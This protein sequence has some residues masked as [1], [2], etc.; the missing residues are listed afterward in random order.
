MEINSILRN[1]KYKILIIITLLVVSCFLTYYF[2]FIIKTGVVFTHFFYIPIILAT[3]WWRYKGLIV[4]AFLSIMLIFS[5]FISGGMNV[6]L[7]EDYVRALMFIVVGSVVAYLSERISKAEKTLS[8]S[9]EKYRSV[10]ESA[11]EAIITANSNGYI[12]S[13]NNGAQKIF[14]YEKDEIL[15]KSVEILIPEEYKNVFREGLAKNGPMTNHE[16]NYEN[17]ELKALRKDGIK[18]PFEIS[19]AEWESG[20]EKFFT[21]ILRDITERKKT[22]ELKNRLAS[23]V[24]YSD[25]AI[26]SKDLNGVINSWNWSAENIYGY[27]A[28]EIIGKPV[29]VLVPENHSNEWVKILDDIKKG[30]KIDHYETIRLKKSGEIINVS[31]TVSPIMDMERIIGAST[32]ARDI[33]ERK[34]AEK[35]LKESEEKFREL[36]NSAN[37]MISLNLMDENGLPGKFIEVNDEGC[38]RLGYTRE[39]FFEM[40]PRDIVAPEKLVEMPKNAAEL[41][42]KGYAEYEMVH[43]TKEGKKIPVDVNNHIFKMK[44][45]TVALAISRDITERKKTEE[46]LK[47]SLNEKEMLIKEIHHRVKNNLMVISS[48]LNLQSK[49]IKDKESL[50]IF[51]ESQSRAQSMALIHERLYRSDDMKK[52]NFGEYIETLSNDLYHTYVLDPGHIKLNLD[53]EDAK[54][55]IN[56]SVPLGLIVNEL[57]SNCMKHAFPAD[58][59][60]GQVNDKFTSSN[61][62][63]GEIDI[64]F[65]KIDDQFLLN[66]K[67]NGIGFPEGLDYENTDS[68][69][70]QLVN[71]LVDQIGGQIELKTENG[72]EF[73]ITFKE[74]YQN[75]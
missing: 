52:I 53:V 22:E 63:S 3:F 8:E 19:G 6:S 24:E 14:G 60:R 21:V 47:Q 48:L 38:E 70:L 12:T 29:S 57:V 36:F 18:F 32:I 13:W 30:K 15:G 4:P 2:H 66:V 62:R 7:N 65:K 34:I 61:E 68:L 11:N 9:E 25:D 58:Y 75:N 20:D 10:V 69:G 56:T 23:I 50:N 35:A 49:Y 37:D 46:A 44:G 42:N 26:I 72:T 55:D 67:D 51:K 39:E 31:L 71:M 54:I 41:A 17:F 27:S 16:F 73:R 74:M 1:E 40:T 59:I 28:D 64:R 33:T 5:H 43:V 45:K